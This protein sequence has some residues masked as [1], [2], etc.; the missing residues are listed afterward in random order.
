MNGKLI[1][2]ASAAVLASSYVGAVKAESES[3]AIRYGLTGGAG[4]SFGSGVEFAGKADLKADS[5]DAKKIKALTEGEKGMNLPWNAG[6]FFG[7]DFMLTDS[8]YAGFVLNVAFGGWSIAGVEKVAESADKAKTADAPKAK[9]FTYK[10]MGVVADLLGRF[11]MELMEDD[12]LDLVLE[13]GGTMRFGFFGTKFVDENDK[14]L[15]VAAA[16]ATESET[17]G[18]TTTTGTTEEKSK[19]PS[20]INTM[21]FGAKAT[22]GVNIMKMIELKGYFTMWFGDNYKASDEAK[23]EMV[24]MN[25]NI[26]SMKITPGMEAG[27]VLTFNIGALI[28]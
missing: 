18:T 25:K 27:L 15:F 28:A 5:E 11:G 4:L 3:M 24:K 9:S 13:I 21:N 2:A 12:V 16:V 23:A 10:D 20:F 1:K 14:D 26:E 17:T 8:M 19:A 22:L 7:M 6:L